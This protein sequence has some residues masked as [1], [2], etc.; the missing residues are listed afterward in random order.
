MH[1][2]NR[3]A[4]LG[5]ETAFDVLAKVTKLRSEGREIVSFSIGEPDFD[6][7]RNIK[8]AGK[9]AI[10]DNFTHYSPSA[11]IPELREAVCENSFKLRGVKCRPEEV[12]I[13]PGAKPIIFHSILSLV[14]EGDE[15]IYPN[16][17][18]P[19]YESMINFVGGKPVPMPLREE[20]GFSFD[21][22]ELKRLVS[23]RTRLIILNSPHNPTGGMLSD[24]D[25]EAVA[26]LAIRHGIWVLADEV[27]H[28]FV[29]QGAF[30]SIASIPGMRE[31]TVI[32]DGCSK[33]YAMTGWRIGWG[34]MPEELARIE[35]RLI[36][37]SDS[38][39]AT[40]T[41]KAA[42]EALT[43]DQ[44]ESYAMAAKF[45]ERA[46]LIHKL[47]N[48]I[49]GVKALMP[50]GAFYI[51]PNITAA[52]REMGLSDSREF[53]DRLL[54]DAGV[55]VLARSC[56]G[57]RNTGENDEYI[58]L[59]FATSSDMIEKG[60]KIMKEYVEGFRRTA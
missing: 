27:Y 6:T 1:F 31:R 52:C 56:F 41:Q 37:N 60:L 22:E 51:F 29:F 58:R 46:G 9:K 32:I 12:V 28:R 25:L 48:G 23:P 55:A 40:F 5:T 50:A 7:P 21:V 45:R 44:K 8:D 49:R 15:V 53:Q 26:A 35:S 34:I 47:L 59:S 36:T 14:N 17:G 11:G 10:E 4:R 33:T 16:P 42:V 13:T 57:S 18:F 39:T 3:T 43:G 38:C 19:I 30:K 2:S 54:Y 24:S 20:R